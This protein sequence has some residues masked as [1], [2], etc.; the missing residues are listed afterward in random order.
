MNSANLTDHQQLAA[1]DE[2]RICARHGSMEEV[3]QNKMRW[4]KK[5][6]DKSENAA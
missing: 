1:E 5:D 3:K 2:Y 4:K 6:D